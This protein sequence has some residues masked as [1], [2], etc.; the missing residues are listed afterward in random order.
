VPVMQGPVIAMPGKEEP[1][2][3]DCCGEST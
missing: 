2:K 1:E 3:C